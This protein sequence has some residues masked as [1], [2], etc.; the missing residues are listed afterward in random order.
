MGGLCSRRAIV[1]N[2]PSGSSSNTNGHYN[3]DS[4][5]EYMLP[6]KLDSKSAPSSSGEDVNKERGVSFS[7]PEINV[8]SQDSQPSGLSP[9]ETTDGIPHLS[10]VLSNKS[11]STKPKQATSTKVS[12]VLPH[13]VL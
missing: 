2:V 11:R 3:N 12:L 8:A 1:E 6:S 9:E 10:R 4:N 7:F 13:P 5:V